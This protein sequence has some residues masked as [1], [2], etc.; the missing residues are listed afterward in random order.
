MNLKE[1]IPFFG[2]NGFGTEEQSSVRLLGKLE[3]LESFKVKD[4]NEL[5]KSAAY[6]MENKVNGK[7]IFLGDELVR[8]VDREDLLEQHLS[9]RVEV[10]EGE[11]TATGEDDS[12]IEETTTFKVILRV[13]PNDAI[14]INGPHSVSSRY[15]EALKE[16]LKEHAG[17]NITFQNIVKD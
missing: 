4:F 6:K 16:S 7:S 3:D 10:T 17:E 8:D 14:E 13:Q 15:K 11:V 12:I 2:G 5:V 1:K 9:Y